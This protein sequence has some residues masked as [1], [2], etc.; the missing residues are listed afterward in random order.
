VSGALWRLYVSFIRGSSNRRRAFTA[1]TAKI[2]I[3]EIGVFDGYRLHCRWPRHFCRLRPLRHFAQ[4][5][6]IMIVSILYVV[7]AIGIT[8][9]MLVALLRPDKF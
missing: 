6:L 9:Y 3:R 2:S 5:R 7:G 4:A 8:V 1:S